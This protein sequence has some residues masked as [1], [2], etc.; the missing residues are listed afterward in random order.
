M[1]KG[2]LIFAHNGTID[3]GSQAVLAAGL[4]SK[5]LGVPVSLVSDIATV[6]DIKSKFD[7]LP[8]DQIIIINKPS[9]TN[10][11]YL[12]DGVTSQKHLI[13]FNNSNRNSAYDLTPYDRTLVIDSD[14]LIFSD[15]L[16]QYWEDTNDFLITP[17]MYNPFEEQYRPTEYILNPSSINM[18]WATNIMF[19]KTPEVKLVFDL[20]EHIREEYVYYAGLYEF[21]PDK[22]RNDFAF[23]VACHIMSGHGTNQWHGELPVPVLYDDNSE[24]ANIRSDQLTFVSKDQHSPNNYFLSRCKNQDVHVLNKFSILANIQSLME[25]V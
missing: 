21:S 12:T 25:L 6:D 19:S 18:L 11:R 24:L 22:Y 17:G 1:T 20:V 7:S 4:A 3:Y 9:V 5:H 15:V 23:S 2:C 10:Y 16:N 13:E 14:F 8:F